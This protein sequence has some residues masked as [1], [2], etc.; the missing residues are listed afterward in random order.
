[1]SD[2]PTPHPKN[3]PGP[4][5]VVNGCCMTCMAP[6]VQA[7]TL[8]GFD[9]VEE[10]CFVKQQPKTDDEIYK[11]IRAV[12]SAEVQCLRYKGNDPEIARRLVEIGEA[13]ACD[14]LLTTTSVPFLFNHFTVYY[15]LIY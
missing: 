6:H 10:H 5:Y 3:A 4:F 8:M 1:M 11:A 15:T 7:P 12:R 13:D 14:V 2:A 9:D